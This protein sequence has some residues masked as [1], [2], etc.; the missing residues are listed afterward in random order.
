[1]YVPSENSKNSS[2]KTYYKNYFK[3]FSEVIKATQGLNYVKQIRNLITKMKT[4]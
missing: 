2:I 3:I 1:M 4:T